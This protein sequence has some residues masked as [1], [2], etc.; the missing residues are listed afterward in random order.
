MILGGMSKIVKWWRAK[1][2]GQESGPA[3][4]PLLV[5]W[6]WR[7]VAR[8]RWVTWAVGSI[9]VAPS[10]Y[11]RL[12]G[13]APDVL[14]GVGVVCLLVSV[15][16]WRWPWGRDAWRRPYRAAVAQYE[17]RAAA[18]NAAYRQAASVRAPNLVV[19]ARFAKEVAAVVA[20]DHAAKR[21][22][23]GPAVS[24]A[25][26]W[27]RAV[28]RWR[29]V[30]RFVADLAARAETAEEQNYAAE[31]R[32]RLDKRASVHATLARQREDALRE[33]IDRL[34]KRRPAVPQ[35][36]I[37]SRRRELEALKTLNHAFAA[38]DPDAAANAASAY[39]AVRRERKA[40]EAKAFRGTAPPG[41]RAAS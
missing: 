30:E 37:D 17:R 23:T 13:T 41:P 14:G 7:G 29:D 32:A 22:G 8:W 35:A 12:R 3:G 21:G 16:P 5:Y 24:F 19:P 40:L 25:E 33:L 20:P 36:L 38:R 31:L 10:L 39:V 26:R 1:S 28:H 4:G 11:G 18:I 2:G 34:R 27:R 6:G 15:P 9:C